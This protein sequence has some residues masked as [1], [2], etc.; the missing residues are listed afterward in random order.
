[1]N[2]P[3]KFRGE[4]FLSDPFHTIE[5]RLLPNDFI[6]LRNIGEA[7]EEVGGSNGGKDDQQAR[8]TEAGGS[9]QHEFESASASRTNLP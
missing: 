5:N 2:V 4:P 7:Y 9:V 1:L 8:P 3:T 6:F